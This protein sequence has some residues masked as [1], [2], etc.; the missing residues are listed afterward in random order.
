[1]YCAIHVN[2]VLWN[3]AIKLIWIWI[4]VLM[5]KSF[6]CQSITIFMW[7]L[8]MISWQMFANMCSIIMN[9]LL[10][11]WEL[12]AHPF[13]LGYGLACL[14][15]ACR[16]VGEQKRTTIGRTPRGSM[17]VTVVLGIVAAALALVWMLWRKSHTRQLISKLPGPAIT[18]LFGNLL[19]MPGPPE[20]KSQHQ[21]MEKKICI[22]TN[23]CGPFY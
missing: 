22:C 21:F 18:P 13:Q 3:M 20:G 17:A 12:F 4:W 14:P 11:S 2:F 1:M 15:E 8:A 16:R 10:T 19:Q 5:S 7:V 23:S 9:I 6:Q